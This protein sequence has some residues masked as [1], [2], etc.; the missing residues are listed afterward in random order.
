MTETGSLQD[1]HAAYLEHVEWMGLHARIGD[2]SADGRFTLIGIGEDR[3]VYRCGGVVYKVGR[4][5][6]A[7]HYDHRTQEQARALGYRWAPPASSLY[8]VPGDCG[9]VPVLAMP[10]LPD[11]G[12]DPDPDLLAEMHDQVGAEIDRIGGNYV[13]R[14]RQPTVVDCCTVG[15]LH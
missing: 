4:R 15:G 6:T 7:N 3:H 10:Y 12:S 5:D 13:V 14:N 2:T 11:D 8:V 9:D 1:A